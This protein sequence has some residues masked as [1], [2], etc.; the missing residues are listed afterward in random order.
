MAASAPST[1]A[2]AAPYVTE[3]RYL[4]RRAGK[5]FSPSYPHQASVTAQD[6]AAAR[7]LGPMVSNS[8]IRWQNERA[9]AMDALIDAHR[10]L[11]G[12]RPGRRWAS[13]QLNHALFL[14]LA[15]EFQ[16]FGRDIHD[17]AV[18]F[19][20]TASVQAP[21]IARSILESNLK[22]ARRIDRGNA[23]VGTLGADFRRLGIP[24][25]KLVKHESALNERRLL[26]LGSLNA[27]R[28]AIAHNEL[29]S[30]L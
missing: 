18:S 21:P 1:W 28:N 15:S 2:E 16:G 30:K 5:K 24:I 9:S 4:A 13:E 11:P 14:R 23:N 12:G 20:L 27:A 17:E 26:V 3:G 6:P 8:L 7:T 25:I 29:N 22:F 19:I 10:I